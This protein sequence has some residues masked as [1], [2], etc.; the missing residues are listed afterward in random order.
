MV[1]ISCSNQ[2]GI[3]LEFCACSISSGEADFIAAGNGDRAKTA[4]YSGSTY[5]LIRTV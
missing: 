5:R 3:E 2:T 4:S 1:L